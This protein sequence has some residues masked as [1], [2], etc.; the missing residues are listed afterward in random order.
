LYDY[1]NIL[2]RENRKYHY[3]RLSRYIWNVI[4]FNP[5]SLRM[6]VAVSCISDV[7]KRNSH[8]KGKLEN[9]YGVLWLKT[10]ILC[11]FMIIGMAGNLRDY[12]ATI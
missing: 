3:C 10:R 1:L 12:I 11:G 8:L 6:R 4:E 7:T 2:E 5:L 9:A